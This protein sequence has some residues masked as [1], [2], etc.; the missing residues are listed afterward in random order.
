MN[1]DWFWKI[2]GDGMT[3]WEPAGEIEAAFEP[4]FAQAGKPADMAVFTRYESE[5][6]LQCEV[7]AYFSPATAP[8]ARRLGAQPCARPVRA[9]LDL[10]AGD[11]RCWPAL[12][13]DS[14][15]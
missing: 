3:A 13:P 1:D 10:L 9:G 15:N 2:L 4:L 8:I 12:F 11:A 5:G 6:R 7:T 14:G